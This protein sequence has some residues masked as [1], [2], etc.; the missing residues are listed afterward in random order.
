[1]QIK[2]ETKIG[3]PIGFKPYFIIIRVLPLLQLL[4]LW[5]IEGRGKEILFNYERIPRINLDSTLNR[6]I[7]VP[8]RV[9]WIKRRIPLLPVY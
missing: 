6:S 9:L 7:I 4:T 2:L 8:S 1:M 5:S 3:R